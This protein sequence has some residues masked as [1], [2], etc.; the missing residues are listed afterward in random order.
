MTSQHTDPGAGPDQGPGSPAMDPMQAL[1]MS[2]E[3]M[4]SVLTKVAGAAKTM[5]GADVEASVTL[6]ERGRPSAASWTG[7]L[8]FELDE[9]QFGLDHGPCLESAVSG[10]II[11]VPEMRTETRWPDFTPRAVEKGAASSVSV[12]LPIQHDLQAALNVY[13]TVPDRFGP[14]AVEVAV[15]LAGRAAVAI[16][17]KHSYDGLARTVEQLQEATAHRAVIEQAKGLLMG[18]HGIDA[19]QAFALLSAMS[20][21]ENKK[22]RLLAAEIMASARRTDDDAGRP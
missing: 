22:L 9:V 15:G 7:L 11:L 6:V 13:G 17:N 4:R 8:A 20:Q 21:R 19:D 14:P 2:R 5:L 10:G 16:S 1:L 3:S 18:R 12:P